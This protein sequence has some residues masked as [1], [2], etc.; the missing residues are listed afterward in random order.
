M[1]VAGSEASRDNRLDDP[2]RAIVPLSDW[3]LDP[4][5]IF[6]NHGSYGATPR[7]VL[8]EQDR[9]RERMERHPNNFMNIELPPAL[10]VAAASLAAFVKCDAKDLVFVENATVG[11][12]AVLNSVRLTTG[13]EILVTDHSYPAVRNAAEHAA[14]KTGAKVVEA[15]VPF[16]VANSKIILDAVVSHLGSRTRLVILD[17]ITS[18]TA[19]IFPIR[20]LVSL[21]RLLGAFVLID[22]AHGPGMLPLDIPSIGADWYV[23]N[24]HKWLMAP[25]GCAF[26]WTDSKRQAE[27][28]PLSISHGYGK[29]YT[30]EFDWT[31]TRDPSAWLCVAAAIDF[32]TRI[33]GASLRERNIQLARQSAA[34]LAYSWHTEVG[35]PADLTGA[36]AAVR[37][38][39]GGPATSGRSLELRDWL[40]K[41]HRIELAINPFAGAMWARISAQAYNELA[42]YQRLAAVFAS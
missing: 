37:L 14:I 20:E 32:C 2:L 40:F 39:L 35:A 9:W 3:L 29:G 22:G 31:G 28:H 13:D 26:L 27:T 5:Y 7:A 6:L 24:C 21:C 36:M 25:K 4:E 12:N 38:P 16:P 30:A 15:K 42:D 18:P 19:V 1:P 10:R 33:G 34:E 11:C 17:H 8:A 41:T 23:G